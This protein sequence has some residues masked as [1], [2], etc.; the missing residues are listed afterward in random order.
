MAEPRLMNID[1]KSGIMY[2]SWNF[3]SPRGVLLLVHG[4][5][6]HSGRWEALADYFL[7]RNIASYALEL[8]GFGRTQGVRGHTDSFDAY[9]DDMLAL[10]RVIRENNPGAK[11]FLAG[12]SFGGLIAFLLACKHSEEFLGLI[13]L[14]PAFNTRI[15]APFWE[16]LGILLNLL[17]CP[18]K[19]F[20]IQ[21]T[22]RMCTR[23]P[24]YQAKIDSDLFEHRMASARFILNYFR[25]ERAARKVVAGLSLPVLFLLPGGDKLVSPQSSKLIFNQIKSLDKEIIEYLEMFH[26]LSVELGKEK[27]FGDI[28][29]W[30][31]KRL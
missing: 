13:C 12:E 20:K 1:G 9:F 25:A 10:S 16:Y 4:F 24:Q 8:R 15:R 5:G 11:I 21:F 6:A 29:S 23:D 31:N 30:I 27:V 18:Q 3:E 2:R 22:G 26:A 17:I 7:Q 19:Q 14:A 28:L